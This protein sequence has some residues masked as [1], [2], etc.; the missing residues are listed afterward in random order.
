M[1]KPITQKGKS[2]R[3]GNKNKK[4]LFSM[5]GYLLVSGWCLFTFIVIGW[6]FVASLS[7]TTEIF[8]GKIFQFETGLHPE[9]YWRALV[10]H[11]VASYFLNSVI[12]SFTTC[13]LIV[14]I[15]APASYAL[16]RYKFMGNKLIQGLFIAGLGIP[17]I[18]I[19]MPLFSIVTQLN[20]SNNRAVIII[21]F[22][23]VVLP[24][25]SYY[26]LTF[27]RNIPAD[28]AEAAAIDG[29]G[30]VMTFWRIMA[31]LAS[32]GIITVT[33]FN[34]ITIWNE[35]F[36]SLI[37]ANDT[38]MRPVAVGLF[39]MIQ[40]MKFTGDWSGMFAAVVVVFMPTFILYL[41]LSEKIVAGITS[42]GV[43]G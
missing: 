30:P 21:L 22:L 36:I 20:L 12:Y 9:N 5:P 26:L 7:T 27:F 29:C 43:K 33:I 2:Q 35:Y 3:L 19:I 17:S 15:A 42:G 28:F 11:N 40:S 16:S 31:P 14:G 6:I 10:S 25:T 39:S 1:V 23:G 34:F 18:M 13:F 37:F 41:V 24:F 8:S 4:R 32:P 38:S